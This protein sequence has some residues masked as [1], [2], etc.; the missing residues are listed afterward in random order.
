MIHANNAEKKVSNTR[1]IIFSR[2][3]NILSFV[4]GLA[5]VAATV[6]AADDQVVPSL[7]SVAENTIHNKTP[8][9]GLTWV[10]GRCFG[11]NSQSHM[12]NTKVKITCTEV[13]HPNVSEY[14]LKNLATLSY[15]TRKPHHLR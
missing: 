8:L 9:P 10:H 6:D 11:C 14:V 15:N 3:T 7:A 5:V 12:Y 2:T 13:G 4:P 1:N